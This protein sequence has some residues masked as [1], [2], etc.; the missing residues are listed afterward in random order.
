MRPETVRPEI[1][2]HRTVHLR[3]RGLSTLR[4]SQTWWR[5]DAGIVTA[6][7]QDLRWDETL[8]GTSAS[9]DSVASLGASRQGDTGGH[10]KAPG[11]S[12]GRGAGQVAVQRGPDPAAGPVQ[13][14]PLVT[15]PE[16]QQ[17]GDLRRRPGLDGPQS[18]A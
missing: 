16:P 6:A 3:L 1:R 14:H 9:G 18:R 11:A 8:G 17:G 4:V 10:A 12:R 5:R 2:S 13:Q 15:V 7:W